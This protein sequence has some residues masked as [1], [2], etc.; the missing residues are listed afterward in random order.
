MVVAAPSR[1]P[2]DGSVCPVRVRLLLPLT[3]FFPLCLSAGPRQSDLAQH[4]RACNPHGPL[5]AYVCK[6]I[7]KGDA[8]GFDALGRIFSGM[9]KPGDKVGLT[10]QLPVAPACWLQCCWVFVNSS[11]GLIRTHAL[12]CCAGARTGR[13]LQ[14]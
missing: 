2:R 4:M 7:P 14:P 6:L 9:V 3:H 10:C 13:E 8:S 12:P 11:V 5:V 1:M